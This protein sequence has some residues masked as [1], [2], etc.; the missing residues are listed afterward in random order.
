LSAICNH[1]CYPKRRNQLN[2]N[3]VVYFLIFSEFIFVY[4]FA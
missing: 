1:V 4:S 2:Q 3:G